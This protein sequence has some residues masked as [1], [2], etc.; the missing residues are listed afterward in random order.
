MPGN[1]YKQTEGRHSI[2]VF[3]YRFAGPFKVSCEHIPECARRSDDSAGPLVPSNLVMTESLDFTET[4][5]A[6]NTNSAGRIIGL[7]ILRSFLFICFH[8]D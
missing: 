3:L 1:S 2:S 8:M 6:I 4:F 7:N 5:I